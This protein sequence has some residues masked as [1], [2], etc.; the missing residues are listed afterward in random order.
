MGEKNADNKEKNKALQH[1]VEAHSDNRKEFIG[2]DINNL[3]YITSQGNYASFF[4]KKENSYDLKEEILR[5]TLSKIES[6]LKNYS[7]IIRCHKSYIINTSYIDDITGNARGYLLK[8][9]F[10]SFEI[11]VSRK[12]SKNSLFG[13][14]R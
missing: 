7:S 8:S 6:N 12:F 13:L 14:L 2:F 1:Y 10:L 9:K 11:P 3:I 4:L 5:V